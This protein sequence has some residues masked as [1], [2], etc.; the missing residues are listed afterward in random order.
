MQTH[1]KGM[2]VSGAVVIAVLGAGYWY[3]QSAA[4]SP[5]APGESISET[6]PSTPE[7]A[8]VVDDYEIDPA[9]F[10]DTLVVADKGGER[11]S[12]AE[13]AGLLLMR[14]EEKFARDV[15]N[16]L[17]A[18]WNL[19][20]FSNIA[21]SEETHTEAVRE[22]LGLY[23]IED[24]VAVDTPGVFQDATLQ[25]L[26]DDFMTKGARSVE[27][28]LVVGAT[29]EELDI[30]DLDRLMAETDN[31]QILSVYRNLQKGSR[32]HLRAFHTQ[33][34]RRGISYEPQYLSAAAYIAIISS[35]QERGRI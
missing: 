22:L 1:T 11:I 33:L 5:V 35:P 3:M 21:R 30:Y 7:A 23:D 27:A 12:D 32:N 15:Y 13:E 2:L 10:L 34:Q 18:Q 24:P 25:A 26:Y 8:P 4:P 31:E 14:E 6:T 29:V 9:D 16:A 20:I 19:Q 17:G 28:A